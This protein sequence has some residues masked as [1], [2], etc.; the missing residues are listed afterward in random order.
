MTR[1]KRTGAAAG[2]AAAALLTT[3]VLAADPAPTQAAITR[4]DAHYTMFSSPALAAATIP[5]LDGTMLTGK[6]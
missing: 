4:D 6:A 3:S 5:F 2:L 1:L